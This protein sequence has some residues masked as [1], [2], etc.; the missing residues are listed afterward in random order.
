MPEERHPVQSERIQDTG[1]DIGVTARRRR[2]V[3]QRC[4]VRVTGRVP[5]NRIDRV[6]QRSHQ[7]GKA[8]RIAADPVQQYQRAPGAISPAP[9]KAYAGSRTMLQ[10]IDRDLRINR[11]VHRAQ[12]SRLLND[13]FIFEHLVQYRSI[14]GLALARVNVTDVRNVGLRIDRGHAAVPSKACRGFSYEIFIFEYET[15]E[16]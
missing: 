16:P 15:I 7:C 11:S 2:R 9:K 8:A 4:R 3:L 10:A 5:G 1:Q 6:R 13:M 12:P 14:L